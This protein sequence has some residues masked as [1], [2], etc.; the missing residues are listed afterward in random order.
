M[1]ILDLTWENG[2]PI[3]CT[4]DDDGKEYRFV[5]EKSVDDNSAKE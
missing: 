3:K 1:E 2:V 4:L 5:I